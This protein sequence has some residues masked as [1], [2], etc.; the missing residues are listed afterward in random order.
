MTWEYMLSDYARETPEFRAVEK[1]HGPICGDNWKSYQPLAAQYINQRWAPAK[2]RWKALKL[3]GKVS[4]GVVIWEGL[5]D[6]W[7]EDHAKAKK[8]TGH[9]KK[10]EHSRLLEEY[11]PALDSA[12]SLKIPLRED[13]IE[14]YKSDPVIKSMVPCLPDDGPLAHWNWLRKEVLKRMRRRLKD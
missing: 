14:L 3:K 2:A 12:A 5:F 8:L 11:R 4:M 10:K 13:V 1:A 9:A 6:Q 7:F